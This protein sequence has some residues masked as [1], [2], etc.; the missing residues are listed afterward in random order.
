MQYKTECARFCNF[1][2]LSLLCFLFSWYLSPTDH[3][4][5]H[6]CHGFNC[7]HRWP[8]TLAS[9]HLLLQQAVHHLLQPSVHRPHQCFSPPKP[10]HPPTWPLGFLCLTPSTTSPS[11]HSCH[12]LMIW[13][14]TTTPNGA[15]S[16]PW[17]SSAS[18]SYLISWRTPLTQMMSSGTKK[19]FSLIIGSTAFFLRILWTCACNYAS[20]LHARSRCP[21]YLADCDTPIGDHALVHQ[22]IR[23]MNPKSSV[24]KM[25]QPLLSKFPTFIEARELILSKEASQNVES[26]CSYETTL[27]IAA[28][29]PQKSEK[30]PATPSGLQH[31]KQLQ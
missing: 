25:L 22:L 11:S 29:P 24:I 4:I 27:F 13:S 26:K 2:T 28:T 6:S 8:P 12:T 3:V 17:F 5:L 23:G 9:A 18:T 31:V 19:I 20:Q 30:A 21:G 7:H 16:S 10:G 15:R 1:L 14:H